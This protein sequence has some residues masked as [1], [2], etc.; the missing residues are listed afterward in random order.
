MLYQANLMFLEDSGGNKRKHFF[1]FFLFIS[2]FFDI[3]ALFLA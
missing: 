3:A 1:S 2:V